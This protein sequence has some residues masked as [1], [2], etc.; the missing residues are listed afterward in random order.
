MPGL[1]RR[2]AGALL[3]RHPRQLAAPLRPRHRRDRPWPLPQQCGSFALR[4][5]GRR[6]PRA[7]RRLHAFDFA[8]GET[9]FLAGPDDQPPGTRFN[10]GKAS[11]DGRFFAGTMDE[12]TL[13]EPIAVALPPRPGRE[14]ARGRRRAHRLQRARPGVPTARRCSTPTARARSSG[15]TTTTRRPAHRRPPGARPAHRGDR[16]PGRRAPW[17]S[18]ATT[19]VRASP[20][21]CS[22]A[23]PRRHRSIAASRCPS[24]EPDLPLL[25][26]PRPAD[27][28]RHLA[29]PRPAR[30]T[31]SPRSPP[32]A[33]SSRY[34][35]TSPGYPSPASRAE[36]RLRTSRR[37]TRC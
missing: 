33:A 25:R 8:T 19:G 7:R 23:G 9:T 29:S 31:S 11:P 27:D 24:L 21:A 30:T 5:S 26:R 20:P 15:P 37:E 2:R 3:G 35:S 13:R 34:G 4:E 28:L 10:D 14:P 22:T 6:R 16:P 17:T 36:S 1:G 32:R 12:K 18:R